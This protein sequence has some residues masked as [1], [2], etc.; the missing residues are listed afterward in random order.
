[1]KQKVTINEA[2]L[3]AVI[4]ESVKR[5]LKEE[6]E[7]AI[8]NKIIDLISLLH[9]A[10]LPLR[11]IHWNTR[12][13]ALHLTTD[14]TIDDLFEWEDTLA[15]AFISNKNITLKINETK[16]S[17]NDNFETIVKDL[18]D[19]ASEIKSDISDNKSYDSVCAV[20]DEIIE[21]SNKHLYRG[22]FK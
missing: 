12:E 2:T 7:N 5:Y 13:N 1:M 20:I 15:E 22:Q 4:A 21:T 19:L 14:E 17:S 16:P 11:E 3:K 10:Q 18:V 6:A 9:N 8:D